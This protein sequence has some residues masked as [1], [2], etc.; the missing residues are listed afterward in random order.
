MGTA[1]AVRCPVDGAGPVLRVSPSWPG[2]GSQGFERLIGE[3]GALYAVIQKARRLAQLDASVL[4]Q[5]ETGVGKEV[6]ARAIHESGPWRQGPFVAVNCGVLLR[7]LAASELFGYADGAFT[8]ARRSGMVGKIEAAN[9]GT[10]FLDEIGEMPLDVQPYLLRVLE[11]GEVCP[12]GSNKPLHVQFRL[13]AASNRDLRAEVD[14]ACFRSDLFYRV[15]VT[16]LRVPSLRE[17]REDISVL[18]EH[19][20]RDAAR[21]HGIPVKSFDPEVLAVFEN[22]SW[23]GNVRELRNAVETMVL[24]AE[25]DVLGYADLPADIASRAGAQTCA[26]AAGLEGVERF[27]IAGA[28]RKH[29]G[30]LALTSRDLRISKST[31]YLKIKKYAL[32]PTIQ[33]SRPSAR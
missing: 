11:G 9:G 13:I 28:I 30:N 14:A 24:L 21:R 20:S 32:E 18:V 6:F 3:S 4:L 23:P 29:S 25:D 5:G 31:L 27:A 2:P 1:V 33:E 16:S 12:V 10:L 26:P 19:F 7:D 17:R 8:G 15:S 22:H